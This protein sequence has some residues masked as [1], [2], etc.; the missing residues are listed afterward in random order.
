M[1]LNISKLQAS[2]LFPTV[3]LEKFIHSAVIRNRQEGSKITILN[4]IKILNYI[5]I[6][7]LIKHW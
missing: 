2:S 7:Y 1:L 6:L 5:G 3:N 4:I